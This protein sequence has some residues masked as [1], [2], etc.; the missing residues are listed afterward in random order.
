MTD[1]DPPKYGPPGPYFSKN[2]DPP[3]QILLKNMDLP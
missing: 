3:E 1:L 2:M